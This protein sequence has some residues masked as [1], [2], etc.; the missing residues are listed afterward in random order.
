M[1]N[2]VQ[3]RLKLLISELGFNI[4]DFAGR[5]AIPYHTVQ[6]YLAGKSMPGGENL[7][8][9]ATEFRVSVDWLLTGEG[10]MKR[11]YQ[12]PGEE[13]PATL[14]EKVDIYNDKED[15]DLTEIVDILKNDLPEA[16]RAVLKILKYRKGIK[17]GVEEL[18]KIDNPLEEG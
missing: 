7:Q 4:K 3:A 14:A 17:E 15:R 8:K 12:L 18:L 5:C 11:G 2:N 13:K 10:N 9:I 1:Q 6:D 16:K